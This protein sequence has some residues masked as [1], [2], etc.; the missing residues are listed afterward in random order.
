MG[1]SVVLAAGFRVGSPILHVQGTPGIGERLRAEEVSGKRTT[2]VDT[3]DSGHIVSCKRTANRNF[4]CTVAFVLC[5]D[6]KPYGKARRRC[7]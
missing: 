1:R 4:R 5:T 2:A 6:D 7:F 3:G